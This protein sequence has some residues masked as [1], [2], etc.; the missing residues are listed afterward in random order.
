MIYVLLAVGFLLLIP[1]FIKTVSA[2]VK[3]VLGI[4]APLLILIMLTLLV[5]GIVF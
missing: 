2:V 1:L 4:A 3:T 5:L